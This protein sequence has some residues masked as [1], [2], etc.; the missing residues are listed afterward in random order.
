MKKVSDMEETMR[1][2]REE[3]E[4]AKKEKMRIEDQLYDSLGAHTEVDKQ[5]LAGARE[6]GRSRG[7]SGGDKTRTEGERGGRRNREGGNGS[8]GEGKG[9][10]G[11]GRGEGMER[12]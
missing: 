8:G 4:E 12:K 2:M 9:E 1:R 3:V 5:V 6:R 7:R 10:G 11:I